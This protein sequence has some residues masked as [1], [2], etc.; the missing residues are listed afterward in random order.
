M[1]RRLEHRGPDDEGL[2]AEGGLGLGNRRLAI[3]DLSPSGH[4]PMATSDGMFHVTYNGELYNHADFRPRLV[5]RGFRFRGT[6]DTETLLGLLSLYG[7]RILS[8]AAGIFALAFWDRSARRLILARD[9]LGVKQLYYQ[10]DGSRIVFASEIKA[11]LED[12]DVP[13]ELDPEGLNQYLHFHTTLFDRTFFKDIRQVQCGEYL[14]VDANG[15]RRRRYAETDGFC[16]RDE[17]P[18]S[19]VANL[20]SLLGSVVA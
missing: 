15:I 1:T 5:S 20:R 17:S 12:P 10:D 2:Y 16:P 8:E 7:P 14:E 6:S 9:P 19:S 4:Q 3:V 13:R 18:A 11:L